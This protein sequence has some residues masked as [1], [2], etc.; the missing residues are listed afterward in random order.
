MET[1]TPPQT[2]LRS[3]ILR[4]I[5][6]RTKNTS[7]IATTI[8]KKEAEEVNGRPDPTPG[9]L[10]LS[11]ITVTRMVIADTVVF[12][13]RH[14][15]RKP[16]RAVLFFHG[17]GYIEGP[18]AGTWMLGGRFVKDAAAEVWIP[19]Y[20]LAPRQ[21]AET[22]VP[23][24]QAVYEELTTV[25]S[26]GA[27]VVS[28]DSAG[29]GLALATVQAASAAGLPLPAMLGL[30]APWVDLTM[31]DWREQ[32]AADPMLD[33][34][35]L[36]QSAKAYAGDLP[37]EDPRVSPLHG[38]LSGLPPTWVI[39]GDDDMLVHQSRRLRDRL[40]EAE[41]PIVYREDPGMAHVHVMLPIPE[42][43]RALD[44]FLDALRQDPFRG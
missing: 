38:D 26:P 9:R 44:A 33:Y 39:V 35:R 20:R 14:K 37:L 42:G 2:S 29:G 11:G 17:G 41:T 36:V 12:R 16:Q 19:A 34:G 1:L 25:W 28:G 3:R 32:T 23:V 31:S 24:A 18:S 15:R 6:V 27:V 7:D 30:F 5:L 21:T 43:R 13:L 8:A 4:L 40:A 10:A 22:T